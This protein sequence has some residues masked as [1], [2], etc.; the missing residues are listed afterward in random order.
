MSGGHDAIIVYDLLGR[1][2]PTTLRNADD[3]TWQRLAE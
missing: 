1:T 3:G 2:P